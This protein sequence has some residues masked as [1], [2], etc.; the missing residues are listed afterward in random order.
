MK[1][2]RRRHDSEF[3]ARVAFEALKGTK[4]LQELARERGGAGNGAKDADF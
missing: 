3:K 1:S 4:T 2:K